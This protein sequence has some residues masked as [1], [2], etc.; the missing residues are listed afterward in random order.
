MSNDL[1]SFHDYLLKSQRILAV[2][3]AGLGA[4]SGLPTFR[5]AGGV[6]LPPPF[7]LRHPTTSFS[8]LTQSGQ[9]WR[10]HNAM[11]LSTPEAFRSHPG[12]VW[13]AC[14]P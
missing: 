7:S 8:V 12:L 2:C 3:G 11:E 1:A 4:S 10:Q 5:G 9:M 14:P 6:R 13:Q